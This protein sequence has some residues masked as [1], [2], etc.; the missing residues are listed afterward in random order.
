M[1]Q[2]RHLW[3]N[4]VAVTADLDD[5][6]SSK[7]SRQTFHR[8]FQRTYPKNRCFMSPVIRILKLA[9][10]QKSNYLNHNNV[11]LNQMH[12]VLIRRP[13]KANVNQQSPER[14]G[15]FH[16]YIAFCLSCTN[17]QC[18]IRPLKLIQ[19]DDVTLQVA[20]KCV[21]AAKCHHV[22]MNDDLLRQAPL[23]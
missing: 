8:N 22:T 5:L 11:V 1:L 21:T 20:F 18:I 23:E 17:R 3:V 6:Q 7:K 15:S 16:S 2:W 10:E 13:L 19:G 9:R 14:G 4:S 12:L